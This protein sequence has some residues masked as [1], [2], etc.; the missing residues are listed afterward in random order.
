MITKI[1]HYLFSFDGRISRTAYC[2]T[3]TA[4]VLTKYG[5]DS[6]VAAR[7]GVAWK[8]WNYFLPPRDL[9]VFGLGE[10]NPRLYVIL[11]ALAIPFFWT[12]IA[13]TLRRLRD[14]G[15]RAGWIFL[16]FVPVANLLF[17]LFLSIAPPSISPE[18]DGSTVPDVDASQPNGVAVAGILIAT[19]IGVAM[20]LLGANFLTQYAWG[21]FLGVPFLAGFVASWFL[22]RKSLQSRKRTTAVCSL[23]ILLIGLLL[24]GFRLEGLVCLLMALP[25]SLPFAIVGGLT[26]RACI[27]GRRNTLTTPR[28][29][30]CVAVL[31][32]LLFLEHAAHL[33]PPVRPVVTSVVIDAPVS[34]VWKSVVAFPPLA[35]PQEWIFHTGIA[36]PMG[37]TITGSGPGAIRRCRFSTGDFIEPI[38]VWDEDHLLAFSVASEPASL[39]EIGFGKISTPHIERNYMRS[40]HGQFRLVA[41]NANQTLLEGT[42]WY[43]DYF[44]PQIY[45]R[46]LSD[47]IIHR[48]HTRV[49]EHVKQQAETQFRSQ[50][51]AESASQNI[52]P[53]PRLH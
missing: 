50:I 20:V 28:V 47:A 36:Y 40:Q 51:G 34:V 42:T 41:L 33:D 1:W 5:I 17:F 44:W 35:E 3:G 8:L 19:V 9:T 37:A 38:T 53:S 16:F 30:A 11:W 4:L 45:W 7:F 27:N 24:I 31:P 14:C 39:Q 29:T 23:T 2:F 6:A 13:L 26:A 46:A 32:L 48:I 18:M 15:Y 21:L 43:Q 52:A 25:L 12:G 10:Q 49:L 22:N